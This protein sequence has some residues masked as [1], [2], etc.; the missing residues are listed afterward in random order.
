MQQFCGLDACP[1]LK[2]EELVDIEHIQLY[3]SHLSLFTETSLR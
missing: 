3:Y 1:T 2:T